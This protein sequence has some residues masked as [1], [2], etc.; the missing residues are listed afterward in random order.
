MHAM[1]AEAPAATFSSELYLKNWVALQLRDPQLAAS[2][3][4][5]DERDLPAL[6]PT[7]SGHVTVQRRT[8]DGSTVYL[9]SARDPLAQARRWAQRTIKADK[10]CYLIEGLGLGYHVRALADLLAG[11]AA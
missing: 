6:E 3:Q 4:H 9:H 8:P 11:N 5:L 1:P 7:A 2:L 10:F